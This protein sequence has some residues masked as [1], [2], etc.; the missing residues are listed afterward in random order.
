MFVYVCK[1]DARWEDSCFERSLAR[2]DEKKRLRILRYV[3]KKDAWR[4]LLAELLLRAV[5]TERYHMRD[6]DISFEVDAHGK[7]FLPKEQ[8]ICFNLTHS[9][10]WVGCAVGTVPVGIDIEQIR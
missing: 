3:H 9:G 8:D 7:P 5:L 4:S 1:L 10:D 2:V 6:E